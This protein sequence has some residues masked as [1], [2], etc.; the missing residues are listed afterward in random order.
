MKMEKDIT[1]QQ[2]V[3]NEG[4]RKVD[5]LD[6][7][8]KLSIDVLTKSLFKKI[9]GGLD[10]HLSAPRP[11]SG[12]TTIGKGYKLSATPFVLTIVAFSQFSLLPN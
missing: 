10:K 8:S 5:V 2:R 7:M 6:L 12:A 11:T 1:C 3:Y 4:T 9:Y